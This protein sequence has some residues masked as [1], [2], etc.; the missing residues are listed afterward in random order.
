MVIFPYISNKPAGKGAM[1]YRVDRAKFLDFDE[2]EWQAF[3]EHY[4]PQCLYWV[5]R[6][7]PRIPLDTARSLVQDAFGTFTEEM[8]ARDDSDRE[9]IVYFYAFLLTILKNTC[10]SSLRRERS[11]IPFDRDTE[12]EEERGGGLDFHL[13]GSDPSL[14][15]KLLREPEVEALSG[16]EEVQRLLD[17]LQDPALREEVLFT[18]ADLRARDEV[19]RSF[20]ESLVSC[21]NEHP[22]LTRIVLTLRLLVHPPHRFQDIIAS[23]LDDAELAGELRGKQN[24][25]EGDAAGADE[26]VQ[27]R[28]NTRLRVRLNKARKSLQ[29]CLLGK[30]YEIELEEIRS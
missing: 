25:P 3:A 22:Q 29:Q 10:F 13:L 14:G 15:E 11:L 28:M 20:L 18:L 12:E 7:F 30:G 2:R 27:K 21:I 16:E 26:Q 19:D 17:C 23:L 6:H 9:P 8:L 24:E 1:T 5:R 4:W